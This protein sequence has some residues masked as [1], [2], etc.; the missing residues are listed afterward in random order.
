MSELRL[1]IGRMEANK[2]DLEG[3]LSTVCGIL[4]E[5][6]ATSSPRPATPS[7]AGRSASARRAPSPYGGRVAAGG[8]YLDSTE[9]RVSTSSYAAAGGTSESLLRD[10]DVD[11]VRGNVKE[12]VAKLVFAERERDD[13]LMD[14]ANLKRQ[15][16]ELM[17]A[18]VNLEQS[19]Q[20]QKDKMVGTEEQLRNLEQ[21]IS[22]SDINIANQVGLTCW[23]SIT[24]KGV[25]DGAWAIIH[26]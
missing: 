5:V 3:K 9:L 17:L 19:L 2:R 4:R 14:L 23:A 10:L 18:N 1:N 7:R 21:K 24:H 8:S 22:I 11:S 13:A 6:R 26:Q 25:L 16:E 15:K 12:L 20:R